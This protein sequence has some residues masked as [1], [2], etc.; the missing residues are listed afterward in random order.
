[1]ATYANTKQTK[2]APEQVWRLWSDVS[3]WP[4][5]NPDVLSIVID[6]PFA[7][8]AKGT[9]TTKAGGSHPI[10]LESVE[11]GRSFELVTAALP[12]TRF[13]FRCEISPAGGGGA[14]ISQALTMRGPLG[15]L[16]GPMMGRK[17]AEGFGPILGGLKAAAEK[18][19]Q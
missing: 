5:W 14:V 4:S 18:G 2:A 3:T 1:M 7:S 11:A 12:G 16:F 9:M 8:G 10:E 17:I 15:G 6:G 19:Q 13:A